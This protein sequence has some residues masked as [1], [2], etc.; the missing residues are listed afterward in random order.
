MDAEHTSVGEAA[1]VAVG[2]GILG[3]L[4]TMVCS[5]ELPQ[6]CTLDGKPCPPSGCK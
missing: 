6:G 3:I 1:G 4:N 5:N 2:L